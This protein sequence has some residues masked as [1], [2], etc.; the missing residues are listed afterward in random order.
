MEDMEAA[1]IVARP[2]FDDIEEPEPEASA[3]AGAAPENGPG[4]DPRAARARIRRRYAGLE[5]G[6]A[7]QGVPADDAARPDPGGRGARDAIAPAAV[8]RDEDGRDGDEREEDWRDSK[9]HDGKGHDDDWRDED[10]RDDDE[11][12]DDERDDDDDESGDGGRA[13]AGRPSDRGRGGAKARPRSAAAT[14]AAGYRYDDEDR[15]GADLDDDA[16]IDELHRTYSRA[17]R[18][19][20]GWSPGALWDSVRYAFR[21]ARKTAGRTVAVRRLTRERAERE[22]V[23]QDQLRDLGELALSSDALDSPLLD[24]YRDQLAALQKDQE[25]RED[26]VEALNRRIEEARREH[27]DDERRRAGEI[28]ELEGRIEN[29]ES[30][31]R[32]VEADYRN[33]LKK[34]R[35]AEEDARALEQQIDRGKGELNQLAK[36]SDAEASEE[37]ARL[38]ARLERWSSEREGLQQEVPRLQAKAADLEPEIERLR[39]EAQQARQDLRDHRD[40]GLQKEAEHKREQQRLEAEVERIRVVIENLGNQRRTLYLDCGRQLDI[41]RPDH[42]RLEESYQQLDD[43]AASIHRIDQE[44]EI[45]QAKPDSPDWS[46]LTRAGVALGGVFLILI[47]LMLAFS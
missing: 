28:E 18:G 42:A 19:R 44:R 37:A 13:R 11:R 6:A 4:P 36:R 20:Q 47:I 45:A 7:E 27:A 22:R 16:L 2:R 26:E 9:E 3:P 10:E 21:L 41:D 39:Q 32:P 25:M 30:R 38:R 34:A 46:A 1:T 29:A 8:G 17:Y 40:A 33:A 14:G 12:D 35:A 31:L 15:P 23:R 43:T 5:R 24:E